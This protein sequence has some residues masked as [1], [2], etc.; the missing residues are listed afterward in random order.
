M[1]K[2]SC[3]DH[4]LVFI[5]ALFPYIYYLSCVPSPYTVSVILNHCPNMSSIWAVYKWVV[6][7]FLISLAQH[8]SFQPHSLFFYKFSLIKWVPLATNDK[9]ALILL[10]TFIFQITIAIPSIGL[11]MWWS[12]N[13]KPPSSCRSYSIARMGY[14]TC[15]V[16]GLSPLFLRFI[17]FYICTLY[18]LH[19]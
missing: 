3:Y 9:K 17:F 7:I 15:F 1:T 5:H 16:L 10:G 12:Y 2:K 14:P 13:M 18:T 4:S 11:C 19:Y 8:T 6:Y